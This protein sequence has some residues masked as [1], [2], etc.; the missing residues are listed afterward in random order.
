MAKSIDHKTWNTLKYAINAEEDE[1]HKYM[2]VSLNF[3]IGLELSFSTYKNTFGLDFLQEPYHKNDAGGFLT[4]QHGFA[5]VLIP[6]VVKLAKD[7]V[8]NNNFSSMREYEEK[9]NDSFHNY[10]EQQTGI[11]YLNLVMYE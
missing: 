3:D 4:Y 6:T 2:Y 1:F 8:Q 11:P 5:P 9:N 10:F 7:Y